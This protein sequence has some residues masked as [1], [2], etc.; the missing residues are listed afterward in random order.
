MCNENTFS[1]IILCL[2]YHLQALRKLN[3]H[4][5][6]DYLGKDLST[7]LWIIEGI[8]SM[9]GPRYRELKRHAEAR[10]AV[11]DITDSEEEGKNSGT[12]VFL[13]RSLHSASLR[14]P[15][16]LKTVHVQKTPEHV[17]T[18]RVRLV[19]FTAFFLPFSAVSLVGF[20]D[21]AVEHYRTYY[22]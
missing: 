9:R 22:Y 6:G 15:A 1:V 2:L 7:D 5:Y 10:K 13:M 14:N 11:S 21:L 19:C 8:A 20:F 16:S 17:V 18:Y 12:R 4:T 3:V